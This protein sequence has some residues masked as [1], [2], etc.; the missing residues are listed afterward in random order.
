M[1]KN[2][3]NIVYV[4]LN[5]ARRGDHSFFGGA[6]STFKKAKKV[7]FKGWNGEVKL[8]K[9]VEEHIDDAGLNYAY[10]LIEL[11]N[12]NGVTSYTIEIKKLVVDDRV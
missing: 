8:I 5:K 7:A 2:K 11:T 6:C 4:I 3:E 1:T 10:Y 12:V 9:S